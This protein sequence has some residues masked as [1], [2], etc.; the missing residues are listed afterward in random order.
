M[1]RFWLHAKSHAS[2]SPDKFFASSR[3][4]CGSYVLTT[5][6]HSERRNSATL[7]H[8]KGSSSTTRVHIGESPGT[9]LG[10]LLPPRGTPNCRRWC[11]SKGKIQE[12][13]MKVLRIVHVDPI[14]WSHNRA[15]L[16]P[17][18]RLRQEA[19]KAQ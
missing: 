1:E 12:H 11:Q 19:S 4:C 10:R 13:R 15:A 17:L 5:R 3:A 7:S 8:T 18:R 9:M 2:K 16:I 14:D 6:N